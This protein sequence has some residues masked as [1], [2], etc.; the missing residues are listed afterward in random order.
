MGVTLNKQFA[1]N[2]SFLIVV[3]RRLSRPA[4]QR[5][6]QSERGAVWPAERRHRQQYGVRL[7]VR[8]AVV[9]LRVAPERHL[10]AAVGL[11]RTRRRSPRRAAT[12]S[13]A[14]CRSATRS[15]TNVRDPHRAAGGPLCVDEDLGQPRHKKFKTW[16]NQSIEGS[17]DLFNTLNMNTIIG[18]DQSRR[19][20][21]V[22]CSRPTSSRRASR[23]S[24]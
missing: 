10:H 6:A 23:G 7:P 3:R 11:H 12:T 13:S 24:A 14:K 18:A 20:G 5:A 19:L 21:G 15:N 17:F 4:R 9:E 1:N 16:R 8:P 2:Y 22:S